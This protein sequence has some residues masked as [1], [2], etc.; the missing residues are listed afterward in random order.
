MK[1]NYD[2][3]AWCYDRFSRLVFGNTQ[4]SAQLHLLPF[5][6]PGSRILIAGGGTGW[7]LEEIAKVHSSGLTIT[8]IDASEKM[9]NLAKRQS[10]GNNK[11]VFK[12]A[13]VEYAMND[14][15]YDVVLTP[16]LFDNFT[17]RKAEQLF[18]A[19]DKHLVPQALWLY[20]DFDETSILSH[21][22]LMKIM[23]AFFRICCG[24]KATQMPDMENCFR[25]RNYFAMARRPYMNGFINSLVYK[26]V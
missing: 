9:I 12:A 3:V 5:I 25:Q 14:D 17:Q 15:R 13:N 1:H 16:F 24:V 11:V 26:K 2:T 18:A 4:V 20:C 7:I 6:P 22:L 23:Y 8:Y 10:A 21:R 19:I